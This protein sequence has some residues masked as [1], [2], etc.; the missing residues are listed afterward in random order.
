M[1]DLQNILNSF[2]SDNSRSAYS[3]HDYGSRFEDYSRHEEPTRDPDVWPPP[4]PVEN[5]LENVIVALSGI[6]K[7]SVVHMYVRLESCRSISSLAA[8]KKTFTDDL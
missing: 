4:T 5:R 1:K 7:L 3:H 6:Q 8:R 2:K